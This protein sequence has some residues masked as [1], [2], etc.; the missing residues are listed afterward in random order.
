MLAINSQAKAFSLLV[1]TGASSPG[2]AFPQE[3]P[4]FATRQCS[5]EVEML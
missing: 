1:Y 2:V 4:H 3:K 5:V